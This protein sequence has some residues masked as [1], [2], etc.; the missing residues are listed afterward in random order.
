MQAIGKTKSTNNSSEIVS[1]AESESESSSSTESSY[2]SGDEGVPS[3]TAIITQEKVTDAATSGRHLP[4]CSTK[5]LIGLYCS[6]FAV[7]GTVG[8]IYCGIE[9]NNNPDNNS[10]IGASIA[11]TACAAATAVGSLCTMWA[12]AKPSNSSPQ[13]PNA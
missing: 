8:L 6:L 12:Y 1:G 2:G 7:S 3:A 4:S 11:F 13:V 10:R 5:L 9:L